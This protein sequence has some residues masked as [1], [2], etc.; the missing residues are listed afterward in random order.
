MKTRQ[1]L[2][3]ISSFFIDLSII[4]T[5][6]I[7]VDHFIPLNPSIG[8]L[9]ILLI[10]SFLYFLISYSIHGNTPGKYLL[11]IKLYTKQN[12][13]AGILTLLKREL[14]YKYLIA[15]ISALIIFIFCKKSSSQISY[16]IDFNTSILI[17]V[18]L[19]LFVSILIWL[20]FKTT[21]WDAF[22]NTKIE[23]TGSS[24]QK[25]KRN[26]FLLILFFGISYF[27]IAYLNNQNQKNDLSFL[28][29]K[30]PQNFNS[31]ALNGNV[32]SKIVFLENQHRD[33]KDYVLE[34]FSKYD[35]VILCEWNHRE[36]SQWKFI[37]ELV[38]DKRF[39]NQVGN[40]FTEYGAFSKQAQIDSL[41]NRK[42]DCEDS[43]NL[44]I[45]K[46]MC[47]MNSGF[48]NFIKTLNKLNTQLPD[49]LKLHENFTD[50]DLYHEYLPT[51]DNPYR[52]MRDSLMA[53]HVINRFIGIQ[54]KRKPKKMFGYY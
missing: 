12:K 14:I 33:P 17:V 51:S 39:I 32:K 28:G 27:L 37:S 11:Q 16:F 29:F 9:Q 19:G 23:K 31:H 4:Y 46:L 41:L 48:Y 40:I 7:L 54:Q 13:K 5:L 45:S 50:F 38:T 22:S 24:K 42:F 43:L 35:I 47:F 44:E 3:R 30:Y 53:A 26:Y 6:S 20:I 21:W 52:L 8:V 10:I 25:L 36:I 49:S 1:L 15:L 18:I 2:S 34:L